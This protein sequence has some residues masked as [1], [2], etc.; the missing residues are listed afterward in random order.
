M[1]DD[2]FRK[3]YADGGYTELSVDKPRG[4]AMRVA[5]FYADGGGV[6]APKTKKMDPFT[7]AYLSQNFSKGGP[8]KKDT[9]D[10]LWL[11]LGQ[12]LG[13]NMGGRS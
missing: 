5:Q 11:I 13:G 1:S 8:I 9:M 12:I 2:L 10:R 6:D 7:L 4:L 3:F